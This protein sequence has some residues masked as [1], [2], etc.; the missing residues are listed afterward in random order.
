MT[1]PPSNNPS[2]TPT[3]A[4][5]KEIDTKDF[6]TKNVEPDYRL[7][8]TNTTKRGNYCQCDKPD[9]WFGTFC[10]NC[11]LSADDETKVPP[12]PIIIEAH[13]GGCGETFVP[14]DETDLYHGIKN[15][16]TECGAKADAVGGWFAP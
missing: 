5:D 7:H 8:G 3:P 12:R 6:T 4:S 2:C 16:G 15:D 1:T 13:C 10:H 11:H 9:F 14:S